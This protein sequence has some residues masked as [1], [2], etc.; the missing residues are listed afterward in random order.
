[1]W[2]ELT[3]EAAELLAEGGPVVAVILVA[4]T[5]GWT[6]LCWLFS[7][8]FG[9]S[10]AP[11]DSDLLD[12]LARQD[13]FERDRGA[14]R[15]VALL[16]AAA[17]LLGLLGTVLGMMETFAFLGLQDLPRVDALAGGVSR[18]LLTPQVGLL[19][20]LGLLAGHTAVGRLLRRAASDLERVA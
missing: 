8:Y 17:P 10:A 18:A 4:S 20:A 7:N 2:N 14:L 13:R 16:A 1:M 9:A 6:I 15:M 5:V 12:R 11:P 3:G 19:S